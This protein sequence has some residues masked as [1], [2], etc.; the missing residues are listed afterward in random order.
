[1]GYHPRQSKPYRIAAFSHRFGLD[2]A[3]DMIEMSIVLTY[4][5]AA[6]YVLA[7]LQTTAII[8]TNTSRIEKHLKHLGS[9]RTR[10]I[11]KSKAYKIT[12]SPC[13]QMQHIGKRHCK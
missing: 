3:T 4:D 2:T 7:P 10:D 5:L 12:I 1:M 11:S 9:N 6:H 8:I 13:I